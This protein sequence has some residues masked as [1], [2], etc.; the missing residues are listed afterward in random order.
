MAVA[1]RTRRLSLRRLLAILLITGLVAAAAAAAIVGRQLYGDV[2]AIKDRLDRVE[3]LVGGDTSQALNTETIS[4]LRQE[5]VAGRSEFL[6]LKTDVQPFL[7][8]LERLSRLPKVGPSLAAVPH[9]LNMGD[10]FLNAGATLLDGMDPLLQTLFADKKAVTAGMQSITERMLA[11]LIAAQPTF[12]L[13]QDQ[14]ERAAAERA[15]IDAGRLLP[16]LA[17]VLA[18]MDKY[19]PALRVASQGAAVSPILLGAVRPMTYVVIAQNN[20]ELRATGG[21]ISAVGVLTI[22][23]GKIVGLDFKDSYSVDNWKR[24]HPEPPEQLRKYM[25]SELWVFRDANFWPDFPTSAKAIEY[26]ADLDLGLDPDGVIAVD[27]YALQILV[28]GL[29]SVAVAEYDNDVLTS[30]NA[31]AKIRNYWEPPAGTEGE[32]KNWLPWYKQR[33]QFMSYLVQAMRTKLESDTKS[34]SL[35]AFA[36]SVLQALNEKHILWYFSGPLGGGLDDGAWGGAIPQKTNDY[37]FVVDTNMGFNKANGIVKRRINY[38]VNIDAGGLARAELLVSY[39]NPANRDVSCLHDSYYEA[40]YDLMMNRCYWNYL[41]VYVPAGATLVGDEN[42]D[43]MEDIGVENAKQVWARWM[44][45]PAKARPQV[46]IGYY[47]PDPV[48]QKVGDVWEYRLL[49]QKQAGTDST[50]LQVT[51]TL[52]AGSSVVSVSPAQAKIDGNVVTFSSDLRTDEELRI[53]IK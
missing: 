14:I 36:K 44:V 26:F 16:Q 9:L 18:R 17:S 53:A 32:W 40:T 20:D 4:V 13:A 31:I 41:R 27:Q 7:P 45:V 1:V 8:A 39:N 47:L 52:P 15:E 30:E 48:L 22:D 29:G 37:L 50:P 19:L 3:A 43:D 38:A 28:G 33:K 51:V 12:V 10:N 25:G 24:D 46:A 21:F 11:P 42:G 49:V 6:A 5:F 35:P 34:I 2:R 23:K